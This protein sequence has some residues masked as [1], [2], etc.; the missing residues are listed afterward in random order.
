M[1]F[2]SFSPVIIP[3]NKNNDNINNIGSCLIVIKRTT[4]AVLSLRRQQSQDGSRC[5]PVP[6]G[7]GGGYVCFGPHVTYEEIYS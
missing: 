3:R 5:T 6:Y 2:Y 7:W 4:S 1:F